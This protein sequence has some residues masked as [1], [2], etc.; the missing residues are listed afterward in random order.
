MYVQL[1][2]HESIEDSTIIKDLSRTEKILG[3][4]KYFTKFCK[5]WRIKAGK[6][7]AYCPGRRP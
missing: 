6:S 3:N 2:A 4:L 5:Q 1:M 7:G